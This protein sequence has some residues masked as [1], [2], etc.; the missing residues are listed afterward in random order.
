MPDNLIEALQ[1]EITR[2]KKLIVEYEKL[3]TGGFGAAMIKVSVMEAEAAIASMDA[4]QIVR[5]LKS[6][7]ENN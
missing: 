6:L 1:K 4:V 7:R 3:P 5:C 2:S